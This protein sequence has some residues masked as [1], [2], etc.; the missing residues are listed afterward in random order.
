MTQSPPKGRPR[1]TIALGVRIQHM[2]WGW[3]TL[4]SMALGVSGDSDVPPCLYT[5][6]TLTQ[7]VSPHTCSTAQ[8]SWD[9][10][11]Q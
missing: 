5:P 11:N 2:D 3:Y 1:S 8:V 9:G 7:A 4:Q 6:V 10:S